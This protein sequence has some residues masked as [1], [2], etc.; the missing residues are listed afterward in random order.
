[1]KRKY[2]S[3]ELEIILSLGFLL[4][5]LVSIN[6]ISGYSF[7]R[8]RILQKDLFERNLGLAA[9]YATAYLENRFEVM[10][11][12]QS[13]ADDYLH[14][15]T[16]R[17]GAES[18]TLF[19]SLGGVISSLAQ[20]GDMGENSLAV[21][22]E[23]LMNLPDGRPLGRL[24]LRSSN[25]AGFHLARLSQWDAIFRVLGLI[26]S[27]IVSALFLK[28]VLLPYRRIKREALDFNLDISEPGQRPG[29]EYTVSTFKNLITELEEKRSRLENLYRNSEQR[30]DS[31]ARYN[32][33]ILG[34]ITSGVIICDSDGIVTRFN[35]SA[36]NILQY[37]EKDCRG[38]H[39]RDIFGDEHKLVS[40]FDDALL[41]NKVYSRL[42]F[43]IQKTDGGRLWLGCSS[44][45]IN[46]ESGGGM[47]VVLLLIDLTEIRRLQE[48]NSYSD[49]MVA[50]GETAAGLAHEV[51]NSFAAI[52]GFAN[53]LGKLNKNDERLGKLISAIKDESTVAESLMSRF[54]SFA[55]PLHLNPE[56]VDIR[57]VVESA[58]SLSNPQKGEV[59]IS[60]Q[61]THDIPRIVGDRALLRQAV[62]NLII[63]A[64]EAIG[65]GGEIRVRGRMEREDRGLN[66]SVVVIDV[67]DNGMGIEP[68]I[69]S[70]IFEPFVSGKPRG[71]GLGLALV[72][73]IVV[74]HGGRIEV[75]SKPGKGT[76]FS[77]F[78]PVNP[79]EYR[80][81]ERTAA[82]PDNI[83]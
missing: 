61:L 76:R 79:I 63:N 4:L 5:F 62:S 56:Q 21:T 68:E 58:I 69:E 55:R 42:E 37:L 71:T 51:R 43:E 52:I 23:R 49:K 34:S 33:Y 38:K 54:L 28:A 10:G 81:P 40:I 47:G 6:F 82:F 32:E 70:R 45:L 15:L 29:I 20:T 60:T 77:I 75:H 78:L 66:R 9:D 12:S 14:T 30:A 57:E 80:L 53:L 74:L 72:K 26:A 83:L 35:P 59:R 39:Y 48:Q 64:C 44:S 7:E 2:D 46:D 67:I 41:H 50:L 8:A 25:V 16:I 73:K 19:D 31:L 11:Y 3:Y 27:L 36:Q 65:S 1:M 22:V 17:I 18:V 24:R 13:V